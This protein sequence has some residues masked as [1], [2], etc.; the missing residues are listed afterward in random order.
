[1]AAVMS[2]YMDNTE[3]IVTLVDECGNMKLTLL[4]PDVNA[5]AY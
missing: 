5:G 4:P 2:A 3:K 1:M